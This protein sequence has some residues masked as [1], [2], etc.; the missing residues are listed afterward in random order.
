M[1]LLRQLMTEMLPPETTT[2]GVVEVVTPPT[3]VEAP[4]PD[5]LDVLLELGYGTWTVVVEWAGGPSVTV[6]YDVRTG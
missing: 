2:G 6:S 1:V 4:V 5:V 3:V